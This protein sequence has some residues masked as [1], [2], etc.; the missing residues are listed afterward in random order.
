MTAK[1]TI[2]AWA[3]ACGCGK[4][5]MGSNWFA[6][7]HPLLPP[8]SHMKLWPTRREAQAAL[9]ASP[10]RKYKDVK[11]SQHLARPRVVRVTVTAQEE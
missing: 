11:L 10:V 8:I 2:R 9:K 6:D 5:F 4:L 7:G 3:I 1:R